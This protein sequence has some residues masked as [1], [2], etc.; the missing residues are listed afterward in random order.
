MP[1]QVAIWKY[2]LDIL[3]GE[4]S[5]K[6]EMP[7]GANIVDVRNQHDDV[8]IWAM[9]EAESPY[10]LYAGDLKPPMETREFEA[11][12]TGEIVSDEDRVYLGT[13]HMPDR[14]VVHVFEKAELN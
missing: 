10:G 6:I 13:V 5:F 1:K 12:Y 4:R 11:V 14:I 9:V 3:S 8:C 2:S 7:L